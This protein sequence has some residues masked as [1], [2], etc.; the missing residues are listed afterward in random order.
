MS[1]NS[2]HE[3]IRPLLGYLNEAF[4]TFISKMNSVA[5]RPVLLNN[6]LAAKK[7]AGTPHTHTQRT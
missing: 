1:L 4:E 5:N 2:R 6:E 7:E 3:V